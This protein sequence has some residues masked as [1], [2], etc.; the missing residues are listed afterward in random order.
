LNALF[1]RTAREQRR[2]GIVA[3]KVRGSRALVERSTGRKVIDEQA[4]ITRPLAQ[5]GISRIVQS[6]A[7]FMWSAAV[8]R[9][10]YATKTLDGRDNLN[11]RNLIVLVMDFAIPCA[12]FST[13]SSTSWPVLRE[14]SESAVMIA[15]VFVA[16]YAATY[17]WARK[18]LKMSISDDIRDITLISAIPG[19]FFGLV[20]GKSFNSTPETASSALIASYCVGA[21]SLAGWMLV[22]TKYV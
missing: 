5:C 4:T 14:Q 21:I 2:A 12:L 22:I 8:R 16:L 19:G 7:V 15:V 9:W 1:L 17:I 18:S 11:V 3:E 10:V 20:F 13:I 6:E